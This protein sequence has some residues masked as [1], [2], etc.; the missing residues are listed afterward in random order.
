[1]IEIYTEE[2]PDGWH[3]SP[4][5]YLGGT[6]EFVVETAEAASKFSKVNV[7]YDG[8]PCQHNGVNYLPRKYYKG[9]DVVLLCNSIPNKLG[10]YNIAWVNWA[11]KKAEEYAQFD[12]RIVQSPYHQSIFG[13]NSRIVPAGVHKDKFCG[14]NKIKGLCLYSSA[15]DRGGMFLKGIWSRV[16]KETGARLISTYNERFTEEDMVTL[17]NDAEFWLHP[18]QGIELF[19]IAAAKAQVAG[20]VPVVVPNMALDTTVKYGVRTTI[21]KYEEDL[22]NAIKNPPKAE[23][24]DFGSWESVTK[25]LFKAV[26]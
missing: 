24:V 20:C 16:A 18:C 13:S 7:Y 17:Y 12:E 10:K 9:E 11:H 23:A 6:P 8:K 15:P 25:D 19:C 22:I 2:L 1:V 3:W 14:K 21:E 5:K 26:I 4:T